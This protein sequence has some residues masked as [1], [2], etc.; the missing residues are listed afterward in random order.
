M[1][2]PFCVMLSCWYLLLFGLLYYLWYHIYAFSLLFCK[3]HLMREN[4]G[5][6]N[7]GLEKGANPS[8]L[9][10][11]SPNALK[12][13]VDFFWNILQI[14]G[15]RTTGGGPPGPHK[16][17][18][19]LCYMKHPGLENIRRELFRG[20]ATATR[21]NLSRSNLELRQDDPAGETSLPEGEII[22]IIITNTPLVG[23]EASSPTSSSAP[24]PL[25]TLV[26]LL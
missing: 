19:L 7:S 9:F 20:F 18:H 25:Q 11:T 5:S 3:V 14:L 12:I 6:W 4:S 26:H 21:R 8:P 15:E 1:I 16:L 24:S 10:C 22:A 23:G 2:R 17:A 13:Y